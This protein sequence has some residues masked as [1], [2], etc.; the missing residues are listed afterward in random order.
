MVV[1]P[2][3]NAIPYACSWCPNSIRIISLS[4][5][6]VTVKPSSSV[7]DGLENISITYL[8]TTTPGKSS[9]NDNSDDKALAKV[10]EIVRAA[11]TGKMVEV[12]LAKALEV[13]ANG[14]PLSG[15]SDHDALELEFPFYDILYTFFKREIILEEFQSEIAKLKTRG[16]RREFIKQKLVEI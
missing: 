10:R 9:A 6:T 12:P 13:V 2:I 7:T 15:D 1:V 4:S 11:D 14:A 16:E 5:Q 8:S 3:S